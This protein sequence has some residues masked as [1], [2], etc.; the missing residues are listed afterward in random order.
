[1]RDMAEDDDRADVIERC[2]AA[3]IVVESFRPGVAAR[4][5]VGAEAL[6]AEKPSLIYCS[7]SG[8]GQTGP[9]REAAGHDANYLSSIGMLGSPTSP[10]LPQVP[11]A[12]YM[13][14]SAAATA[15]CAALAQRERTGEGATLDI[16]LTDAALGLQTMDLPGHGER[17][18]LLRGSL[19]CYNLYPGSDGR[20]ICVAAVEPHYWANVCAILGLPEEA[21][22]NQYDPAA[23]PALKADVAA[24]L[25]EQPADEWIEMLSVRETCCT[26][27]YDTGDVEA[28]PQLAARASTEAVAD[29]VAPGNPYRTY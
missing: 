8:Y 18:P 14:G 12:D 26:L 9:W 11:Y 2:L 20:Y 15:I 28:H 25:A 21:L 27:V 13:G 5:G 3:D 29:T 22:A 1:M 6:R 19:A 23:Q 10:S 4:L 16:S 7:I 24:I 17:W